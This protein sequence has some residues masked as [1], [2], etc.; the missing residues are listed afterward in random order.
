MSSFFANM[1]LARVIILLSIPGSIYLGWAGMER[2]EELDTLRGAYKVQI[3]NVVREIQELSKLNTKLHKDI[4]GDLYINLDSP[5]VYVRACADNPAVSI[6]EVTPNPSSR[7]G[8]GGVIDNKITIR[9][10][11]TS[12]RRPCAAR[13]ATPR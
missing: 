12:R 8:P 13:R 4:K 9:P 6:G 3:P 2:A 10:P 7:P 5:M 1:S 11:G